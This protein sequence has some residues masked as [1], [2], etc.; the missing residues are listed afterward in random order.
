MIVI[1]SP[2]AR[3][4]L[5]DIGAWIARD[6]AP[7]AERVVEQLIHVAERI[8]LHPLLYPIVEHSRTLRKT[9][10]SPYLIFYRVRRDAVFIVAVRHGARDN[11]GLR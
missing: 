2:R 6:D 7:V 10:V 4:D 5:I 9:L 3:R 8:G 1:I 11:R